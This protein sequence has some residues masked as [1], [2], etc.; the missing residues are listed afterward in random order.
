MTREMNLHDRWP[1]AVVIY[2]QGL[3]TAGVIAD[4]AGKGAGWQTS[5]GSLG[6]RDLKLVDSVL[7]W[8]SRDFPV[9]PKRVFATGH[10]NGGWFIY[11][12]WVARPDRF[13]AFAPASAV[14]GPMITEAKPKPALIVAGQ[15]DRLVAF[16]LQR[17]T[18]DAVLALN[19]AEAKGDPWFGGAE[20]HSSKVADVVTY[21]HPGAHP[22]PGNA[23]DVVTKFFRS[24]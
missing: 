17:R 20:R 24:F 5:P 21:V 8:A 9:D 18:I 12:L 19:Q 4:R 15:N 23:A 1:E 22:L 14:F 6:D 16:R 3:P 2:L 7:A 11:L 10:S 13:T